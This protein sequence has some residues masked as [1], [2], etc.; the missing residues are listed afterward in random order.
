MKTTYDRLEV[1][2][3]IPANNRVYLAREE[4]SNHERLKQ[5]AKVLQIIAAPKP[6]GVE[7][8]RAA[9]KAADIRAMVCRDCGQTVSRNPSPS[10]RFEIIDE[11]DE[12]AFVSAET[13]VRLGL[14]EPVRS[15]CRIGG[16]A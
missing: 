10:L 11:I 2:I 8:L 4:M 9:F 13:V 16:A 12:E 6:A 1:N 3:K 7:A 14:A 5:R 15:A